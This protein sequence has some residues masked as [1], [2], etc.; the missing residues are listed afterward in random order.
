MKL[1]LRD[2][3]NLIDEMKWDKMTNFTKEVK[4]NEMKLA[5]LMR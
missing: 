4:W 3:M 1:T 5:L 2:K